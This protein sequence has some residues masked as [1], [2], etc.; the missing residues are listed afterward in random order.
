MLDQPL[1]IEPHRGR[2][3]SMILVGT[4]NRYSQI[5]IIGNATNTT[6]FKKGRV[7]RLKQ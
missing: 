7:T 6:Q 1:K 3:Q 5:G 4:M 2:T